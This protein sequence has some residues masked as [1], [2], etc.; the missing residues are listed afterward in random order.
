MESGV[1]YDS[2]LLAV[3]GHRLSVTSAVASADAKWLFTASKDGNIIRWRLRDG[4]MT[5]VLPKRAKHLDEFGAPLA[6][7]GSGRS[8]SSG[9]ARRRARLSSTTTTSASTSTIVADKGKSKSSTSTYLSVGEDQGH[10][11]EIW[12]LSLS[13]DGAFLASGGKDKR[14]CIWSTSSPFSEKFVKTLSGHK[15]AISALS[16]RTGSQELYTA[17]LDRTLKLYDVAQLSYIE[18][19]SAIKN[20]FYHFRA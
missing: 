8:K 2:S 5:R 11:D 3:R 14:V 9:A 18:T 16:F 1:S 15:D 19:L 12:S 10:T 20:P 7:T 17:S 4:K 6:P 13:S